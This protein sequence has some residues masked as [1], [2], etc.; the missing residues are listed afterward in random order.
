MATI[1]EYEIRLLRPDKTVET[2]MEM[3]QLTDRAAITAARRIAGRNPYEVWQGERKVS[4]EST[5]GTGTH[6]VRKT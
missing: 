2:V 5:L 4:G 3:V 6:R 1:K